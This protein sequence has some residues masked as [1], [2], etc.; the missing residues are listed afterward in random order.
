MEDDPVIIDSALS[1]EI[2]VDGYRFAVNIFR[3]EEESTWSLEVVDEDNSSHVW[4][5]T[6]S[7]DFAALVEAQ[8]AI[9]SMG[10]AAFMAEDA[11]PTVH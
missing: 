6:F 10:A 3:L 4:G 9:R 5:D 1:Q 11:P 7:S 2:E 8:K